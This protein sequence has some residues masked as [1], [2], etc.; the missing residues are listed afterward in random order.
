M[1]VPWA[2]EHYVRCIFKKV[3]FNFQKSTAK[4]KH[5]PLQKKNFAVLDINVICQ[6]SDLWN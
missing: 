2:M 3:I 5:V 6:A 4:L 1:S